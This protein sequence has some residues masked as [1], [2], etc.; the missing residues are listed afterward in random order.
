MKEKG[1]HTKKYKGQTTNDVARIIYMRAN[2]YQQVRGDDDA[3]RKA[4]GQRKS[5]SPDTKWARIAEGKSDFS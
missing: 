3:D 5:D 4:I 2:R 1:K